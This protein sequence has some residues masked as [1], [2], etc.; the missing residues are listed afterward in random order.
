MTARVRVVTPGEY[1]SW[2]AAQRQA[3]G[4]ANRSAVELRRQLTDDGIL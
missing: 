3:I 4:D 1:E 2:L